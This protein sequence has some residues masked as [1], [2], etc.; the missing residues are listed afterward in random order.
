MTTQARRQKGATSVE[1]RFHNAQG[2][3]VKTRD[4]AFAAQRE[5]SAEAVSASAKLELHNGAVTFAIEV[6]YNPN[7]YPYV[8]LGGRITSGICGAPWDIT[9]GHLGETIRL[10][11]KNPAGPGTCAGTI[12]VV[13]EYQNPP[14]Y[15]GTYGFNGATS[16]FKH[17]TVYHC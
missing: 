8:V 14:A 10:D 1:H 7:T 3:E 16:S 4:E 9:G 15:R 2:A 17:T 11:A 6:K 12:T 5:V 13:G